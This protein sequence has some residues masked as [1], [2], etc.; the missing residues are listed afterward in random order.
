MSVTYVKDGDLFEAMFTHDAVFNP[1][2][3][4]AK[5]YGGVARIFADNY[6]HVQRIA[7]ARAWYPPGLVSLCR[8]RV[9]RAALHGPAYKNMHRLNRR[10]VVVNFPTM[11]WGELADSGLIRLNLKATLN[12]FEKNH[13]G[14][15]RKLAM[16]AL[17]CG[18]GGV[19]FDVLKEIVETEDQQRK[20]L[21]DFTVFEPR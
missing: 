16:P 19:D 9:H 8:T 2:N 20:G 10:C 18:I 4:E 14:K 11:I 21:Y 3:T 17:G 1:I 6:P 15:M 12:R 7:K 13:V 5:S